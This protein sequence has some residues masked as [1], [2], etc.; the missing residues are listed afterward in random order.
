MNE[1]VKKG[2]IIMKKKLL[3]LVIGFV[4]AMSMT[5]TVLAA[6]PVIPEEYLSAGPTGFSYKHSP[7]E[8]KKISGDILRH[9]C[10]ACGTS[11]YGL[12]PDTRLKV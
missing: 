6:G 7:M 1:T 2:E 5:V 12:F 10:V 4:L 8:N 9:F 11:L 3:S